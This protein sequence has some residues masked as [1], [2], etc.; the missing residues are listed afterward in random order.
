MGSV[1]AQLEGENR[2]LKAK[3]REVSQAL[4]SATRA[5]SAARQAAPGAG[6]GAQ[7]PIWGTVP[8]G[9]RGARM[10]SEAERKLRGVYMKI[11]ELHTANGRLHAKSDSVLLTSRLKGLEEHLT[12]VTEQAKLTARDNKKLKMATSKFESKAQQDLVESGEKKNFERDY[13]Y[14]S[15]ENASL[16]RKIKESFLKREKLEQLSNKQD[17]KIIELKDELA[18]TGRE[19]VTFKQNQGEIE[20]ITALKKERDKLQNEMRILRKAEASAQTVPETAAK[21][22][23]VQIE[24]LKKD[25]EALSRQLQRS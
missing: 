16:Q 6:G 8:T 7:K 20:V 18:R 4:L 11:N 12:K 15:H 5:A 21:N 14:L 19:V 2:D 22:E 24:E 25:A 13:R 9:G 10:A 1:L 17:R 23:L 3:L